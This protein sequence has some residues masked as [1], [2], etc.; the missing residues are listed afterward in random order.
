[1]D[2]K[3]VKLSKS[4]PIEKMNSPAKT[5]IPTENGA[6]MVVPALN[7]NAMPAIPKPNNVPISPSIA[8]IRTKI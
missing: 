5:F 7:S 4:I 6:N 8:G 3:M 1:M 2:K